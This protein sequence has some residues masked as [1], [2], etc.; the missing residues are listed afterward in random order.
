MK[1]AKPNLIYLLYMYIAD[2]TLNKLQWLICHKTQPNRTN[3]SNKLLVHNSLLEINL[4]Q[5]LD[6]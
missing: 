5:M 1:P 3:P 4:E 2:L 6:F